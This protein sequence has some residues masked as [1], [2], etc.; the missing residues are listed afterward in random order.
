[1]N[2]TLS[3]FLDDYVSK[4]L[5]IVFTEDD[6]VT[7]RGVIRSSQDIADLF[8]PL[9]EAC[10]RAKSLPNEIADEF[11]KIKDKIRS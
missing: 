3:E 7:R 10:N 4:P 6:K 8:K 5:P 2:K 1:M 11:Y 9:L